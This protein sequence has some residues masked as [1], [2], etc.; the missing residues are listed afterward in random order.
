M[1]FCFLSESL[2]L[3]KCAKLANLTNQKST[4]ARGGGGGGGG[5]RGGLLLLLPGGICAYAVQCALAP[6][7]RGR[8]GAHAHKRSLCRA[9]CRSV[10]SM[11]Y[12]ASQRTAPLVP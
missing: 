3:S 10:L 8:A 6:E 9:S 2:W 7:V 11:C 5:G 12:V 1:A 4:E